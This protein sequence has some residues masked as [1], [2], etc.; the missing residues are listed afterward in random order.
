MLVTFPQFEERA[1]VRYFTGVSN[2]GEILEQLA[3]G[4]EAHAPYAFVH[5][6]LVTSTGHLRSALFTALCHKHNGAMITRSLGNELVVCL[7]SN[8]KSI[9]DLL[10]R[11]GIHS[12]SARVVVVRWVG[13]EEPG[14]A[15]GLLVAGTEE[16]FTDEALAAHVLLE[17]VYK[18]YKLGKAPAA[19]P[20]DLFHKVNMA[21]QMSGV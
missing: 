8:S 7:S 17:E 13:E 4:S 1:E 6:D 2:A 16:A 11:F 5:G 18:A 12:D 19:I 20:E 3:A 10:K 21:I 14:A 9:R 15:A